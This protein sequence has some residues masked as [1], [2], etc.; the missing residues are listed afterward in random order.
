M[1]A[2]S[3]EARR[4]LA[5][6]QD[7]MF[8]CGEP[9]RL[10][11]F[12]L[13]GRLG[14]GAMGVVYEARD[15][16]LQRQVA[17]KVLRAPNDG[18][19]EEIRRE[20]ATLARVNHPNVVQV[21]DVGVE[22]EGVFVAMELV[23][24]R[25][26][27]QWLAAQPRGPKAILHHFSEAGRGLQA[28]HEAGVIHRDF[29]PANVLVADDGR[30]RVADFGLARAL[31]TVTA[32]TVVAAVDVASASTGRIAGT[33]R[34]MAPAQLEGAPA[35][36]ASDQYA[37]CVALYEALYG[38]L[39]FDPERMLAS[40]RDPESARC[41]ARTGVPRH[42]RRALSRGLAPSPD[43][44]FPSIHALVNALTP[45]TS[46]TVVV[47]AALVVL[48]VA[49]ILAVALR[50]PPA[51]PIAALDETAQPAPVTEDVAALQAEFT[52]IR[53]LIASDQVDDARRRARAAH[54]EADRLDAPVAMIEAQ[55]VIGLVAAREGDLEL[56]EASLSD[57][58]AKAVEHRHNGLA[59]EAA[60]ELGY[61]AADREDPQ[62][63]DQW[64]RRAIAELG[65][66]EDRALAYKV[67]DLGFAVAVQGPDPALAKERAAALVEAAR[68]AD[69][70]PHLLPYALRNLGIARM[71]ADDLDGA[72]DALREAVAKA[73]VVLGP[74]HSL[75]AATLVVQG[76]AEVTKAK[77]ADADPAGL[78]R[79][80]ET[81]QRAWAL[82]TELRGTDHPS[83]INARL[84]LATVLGE[85]GHHDRARGHLEE[86]VA[87]LDQAGEA[88]GTMG[89]AQE[90]LGITLMELDELEDAEAMLQ[91]ASVNLSAAHGT[92][93]ARLV[94][95]WHMLGR[96][97]GLRRRF[98]A[99]RKS[100]RRALEISTAA[101]LRRAQALEG[102]GHLEHAAGRSAQ[103]YARLIEA[104][105]AWDA[106]LGSGNPRGEEARALAREFGPA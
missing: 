59:I 55:L 60:C 41:P 93:S 37:F 58:H 25:T 21:F 16:T 7:K 89:A 9:V 19:L 100:Y 77:L 29:K 43:D 104:A 5:E 48:G 12:V 10:G 97:Q 45:G 18:P 13:E 88:D 64:Y 94:T 31:T 81:S 2:V 53:A 99:G 28:A 69:D 15:E 40:K 76:H 75:V 34:Y 65:D 105:E 56:A 6:L 49:S 20:A 39:P 92:D 38:E 73:E 102:F 90:Q 51:P 85:A 30:V 42:V 57:A 84:N 17:L 32:P 52:A 14:S 70:Q 50:P 71:N 11:R 22:D 83:T 68:A 35:D 8:G 61:A 1:D 80:V 3:L 33:P 4:L 106:A 86:T 103:A 78:E 95:T 46:R 36:A 62:A 72:L 44:R 26:L 96:V 87:A 66:V 24:G 74:K 63:A 67:A 101:P 98:E 23:R 91:R 82:M 27:T 54:E 47:V 79:A